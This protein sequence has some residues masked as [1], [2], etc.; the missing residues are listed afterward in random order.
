MPEGYSAEAM[1]AG[2][3]GSTGRSVSTAL[4]DDHS[5]PL[6]GCWPSWLRRWLGLRWPGLHRRGAAFLSEL[7]TQL[8]HRHASAAGLLLQVRSEERR[9]GN[10]CGST[11][12]SRW[13]QSH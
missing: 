6:A 9:V 5:A 12:G 7:A 11:C 8:L 1:V 2:L 3:F 10:E 13:A 4:R